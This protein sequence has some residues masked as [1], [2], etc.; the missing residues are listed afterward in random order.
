MSG[1][2]VLVVDDEPNIRA[3]LGMCL[4]AIGC[5]V[6]RAAS[7]AE[8]QA[9][10]QS[11]AFDLAFVDLRLGCDD[12]IALTASLVHDHPQLYA[13]LITAYASIAT[14][15]EAIRRGARDYLAKPFT[16][17]QVREVVERARVELDVLDVG[18]RAEAGDPDQVLLHTHSAAMQAAIDTIRQAASSDAPVLLR[19]ESGTGKGVLARLLHRG[20]ARAE[21][22]LVTI[23][24]PTLGDELL[25]SELFG[26]VRGAF[27]GAVRDQ[28]G[29]V[30]EAEG[31]TLFL[32][33]IAEIGSGAQAKL[34]RFVQDFEFERVGEARTRRADLRIVSAT[35]RDVDLEVAAGRMRLDLL[36]RLNVIEVEVPSLRERA[37]D[38]PELARH[39]LAR[40]AMRAN[41]PTPS[42]SHEAEATLRGHAWPGNVRELR[43]EMER[44][45][46]LARGPTI[47]AEQLS[48]R[49]R[50]RVERGPELG[51]RTTLAAIEQ[52]H[53]LGVLAECET[54][55]QAAK[56]LGIN[57]ST[58]WR[59]LKRFESGE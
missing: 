27:T 11:K 16:P 56:I 21:R 39:F 28:V 22:P 23:N 55:E 42:L 5:A 51:S 35:N 4:E 12:G 2:R 8:A 57:P 48:Q 52:R 34:L 31:G 6:H 15:V 47:A 46:V 43:N 58:L 54:R 32:D 14:A 18:G 1:L 59:R 7:A 30:E 44:A 9:A 33:E 19:G 49:V 36:Y 29:R 50:A 25:T 13:V 41:R 38:I 26:H 53:I 10:A 40:A 45:L 37:A 24:C 20:S 17:A 3:T